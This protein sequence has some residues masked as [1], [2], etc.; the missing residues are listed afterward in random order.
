MAFKR[1]L[2][3]PQ[4]DIA[5]EGW[6]KNAML[7]WDEIYTIVPESISEPYSTEAA[8]TFQSEG[9]LIP[10]VINPNTAVVRNLAD[11]VIRYIR[12]PEG[13]DVLSLHKKWKSKALKEDIERSRIHPDKM[14]NEIR[15]IL[16]TDLSKKNKEGF[17]ETDRYFANYYMTLLAAGVSEDISAG[18]LT[19]TGT[20]KRL[21]GVASR[22][23]EP[24]GAAAT[25]YSQQRGQRHPA[26]S[27]KDGTLMNILIDKITISPDTD[28]RKI[29]RFRDRCRDEL[30][31]FRSAIDSLPFD[32][33]EEAS[34]E[35]IYS[36]AEKQY[37][38]EIA[39]TMETFR[40]TLREY[41]V[42]YTVDRVLEISAL[43]ITTLGL[44]DG[45]AEPIA[46]FTAAGILIAGHLVKYAINRQH[47]IRNNPY[48]YLMRM[49]K[50]L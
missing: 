11:E 16:S 10:Y 32:I 18:L 20:Y 29:L 40:T 49:P 41:G 24:P 50:R 28:I 34:L 6:L 3:Y 14:S 13:E 12:S 36:E 19:N 44:F 7:Y 4:I 15:H 38:D 37:R 8:K 33:S 17:I 1:A 30:D 2:F 35:D 47:R 21:A 26:R 31:Q 48:S 25:T 46:F 9:L 39:P 43:S 27:F 5:D 22:G 45:S 23:L 42:N